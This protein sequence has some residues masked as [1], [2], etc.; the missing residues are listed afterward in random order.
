MKPLEFTM[1][2][3]AYRCYWK[4]LQRCSDTIAHQMLEKQRLLM[5]CAFFAV[6]LVLSLVKRMPLMEFLITMLVA[7]VVYLAIAL[8]V[9][10]WQMIHRQMTSLCREGRTDVWFS[11]PHRVWAADGYY[12]HQIGMQ[13]ATGLALSQLRFVRAVKG[14]GVVVSFHTSE[15]YLRPE[16]FDNQM[17]PATF[18]EELR[19]LAKQSA[20]KAD[21]QSAQP[22]SQSDQVQETQT[23][24]ELLQFD[25]NKEQAIELLCEGARLMARTPTYK[26]NLLK[27]LPMLIVLGILWSLLDLELWIMATFFVLMAGWILLQAFHP[28]FQRKRYQRMLKTE[29][30]AN[31]LGPQEMEFTQEKIYTQRQTLR[32][33][34]RY[35]YLPQVLSGE[36]GV[37]LIQRN[38]SG[39]MI[40]PNT[41]FQNEEHR[42]WFLQEYKHRVEENQAA[43]KKVGH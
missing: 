10:P 33:S 9:L 1:D 34:Y 38:C 43:N 35:E 25:L 11:Q 40:I 19:Q 27:A 31:I 39:M 36:K 17:T 21:E 22:D 28:G 13:K 29:R 16:L 7:I 6:I 18:C 30:F 32:A 2:K 24:P 15:D 12:Y 8:W 5:G 4:M 37:Y 42:N 14:G 3:A 20:K 26:K 23:K 41:A